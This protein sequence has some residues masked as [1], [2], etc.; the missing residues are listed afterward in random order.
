M[1]VVSRALYLSTGLSTLEDFTFE[2]IDGQT[3]RICID[4]AHFHY[5]YTAGKYVMWHTQIIAHS[6]ANLQLGC[7]LGVYTVMG[8][9]FRAFNEYGRKE[10]AEEAVRFLAANGIKVGLVTLGWPGCNNFPDRQHHN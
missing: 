8:S 2:P 4:C 5:S 1:R 9:L 10:Q 3:R 7:L 6:C